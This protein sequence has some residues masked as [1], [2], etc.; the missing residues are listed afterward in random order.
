MAEMVKRNAFIL[1]FSVFVVKAVR[2]STRKSTGQKQTSII[3]LARCSR[4]ITSLRLSREVKSFLR[5]PESENLIVRLDGV[6]SK[7]LTFSSS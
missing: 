2:F 3:C 7:F 1:A 6:F 5:F 4:E